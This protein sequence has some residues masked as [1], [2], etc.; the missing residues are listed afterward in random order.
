MSEAI[1]SPAMIIIILVVIVILLFFL[2]E[3]L[4]NVKLGRATCKFVGL[5]VLKGL[6]LYGLPITGVLTEA[7]INSICDLLPL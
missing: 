3:L 4:F 6:G 5:Y 7:G 2:V 1:K